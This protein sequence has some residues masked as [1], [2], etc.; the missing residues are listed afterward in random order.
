MRCRVWA[1]RATH[2]DL[3]YAADGARVPMRPT[4]RGYFEVE[5]ERFTPGVRYGFSLDAGAL[6]PDPRSH[7]QPEGVH[8]PSELTA[9]DAFA[10]TDAG[11]RQAP[12]AGAIVYELHVGTFSAE[13]SFDA[14]IPKLDHL[15]R[16]G[17]THVELLPVAAFSGARGWGYDGVALFA[18][19]A[20]YG[21]PDALR[22]LVDAC[23]ARGL[24]L[25]LDV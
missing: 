4:D 8:G 1:P 20:A 19:H 14:V 3:V 22:R 25:I 23:H 7:F 17:V 9:L 2:V 16:L 13:G 11:F 5:H 6:Y 12:L 18:P 15:K 21:D 10:W 24:A